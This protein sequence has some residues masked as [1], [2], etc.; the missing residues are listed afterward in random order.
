ML[1][2]LKCTICRLLA[3]LL[4]LLFSHYLIA[5]PQNSGRT[6]GEVTTNNGMWV[7]LYPNRCTPPSRQAVKQWYRVQY[8]GGIRLRASPSFENTDPSLGVLVC[9][10]V[11]LATRRYRAPGSSQMFLQVSRR[12]FFFSPPANNRSHY[13]ENGPTL[14]P[15]SL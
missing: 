5:S 1:P 14:N 7:V 8:P 10:W 3:L 6:G 13:C 4:L 2:A 11:F 15:S 12:R 9:G